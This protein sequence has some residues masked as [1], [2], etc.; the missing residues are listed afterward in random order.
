[1]KTKICSVCKTAKPV[2][3]F[4]RDGSANYLRYDCRECAR[5]NAKI[6][7]TIRKTAPPISDLHICPICKKDEQTIRNTT[8]NPRGVWCLDHDHATNEFRDYLCHKCN[9]GLGNFNDNPVL[10]QAALHYL[11]HHSQRIKE[12]QITKSEFLDQFFTN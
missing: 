11:L 6:V 9:M 4:G 5:T 10:M 3:E 1:M 2:S 12:K 7:N 8:S